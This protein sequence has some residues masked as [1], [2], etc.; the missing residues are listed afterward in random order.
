MNPVIT[1]R[2]TFKFDGSVER[3]C[4]IQSGPMSMA[5]PMMIVK[6]VIIFSNNRSLLY[7]VVCISKSS[8]A[9]YRR[10]FLFRIQLV[11]ISVTADLDCCLTFRSLMQGG[12]L[13]KLRMENL[14][15][16]CLRGAFGVEATG[17]RSSS[18][19]RNATSSS[20]IAPLAFFSHCLTLPTWNG[21]AL[22]RDLR[23]I[24]SSRN[25]SDLPLVGMPQP[26]QCM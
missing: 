10:S 24:R 8:S 6:T 19:L 9:L 18:S 15:I 14:S 25:L 11:R 2:R 20:T 22:E 13:R 21:V 5:R 1:P 23:F 17:T 4:K 16:S 26:A 12:S 3:C 7:T